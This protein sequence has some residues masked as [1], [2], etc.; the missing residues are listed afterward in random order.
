MYCK[1]SHVQ[2]RNEIGLMRPQL[3]VPV[4]TIPPRSFYTF[5]FSFPASLL[6]AL[7]TDWFQNI[8]FKG[9]L[10]CPVYTNPKLQE[11]ASVSLFKNALHIQLAEVANDDV[12]RGF[13]EVICCGNQ[14]AGNRHAGNRHAHLHAGF[15]A[16]IDTLL[17][18]S[19]SS[20]SPGFA[21]SSRPFSNKYV[22]LPKAKISVNFVKCGGPQ[23]QEDFLHLD[24][25]GRLKGIKNYESKGAQWGNEALR[26]W[27]QPVLRYR[28]VLV[29]WGTAGAGILLSADVQKCEILTIPNLG[30][31][32]C[33]R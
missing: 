2:R 13:W 29:V 11:Q 5:R 27:G 26:Q 6:S 12:G 19:I 25:K 21:R 10:E 23:P 15:A 18:R 1:I 14:H 20:C 33:R 8:F 30:T 16:L 17:Y 24:L 31:F 28:L 7:C 9:R 32:F 3:S 22:F 4:A